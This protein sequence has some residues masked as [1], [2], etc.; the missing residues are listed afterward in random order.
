[1]VDREKSAGI[2]KTAADGF[3]FEKANTC[4]ELTIISLKF[5]QI[6]S[7]LYASNILNG[8]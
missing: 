8:D 3:G 7:L 5:I 1:M 6:V 2:Y 4:H